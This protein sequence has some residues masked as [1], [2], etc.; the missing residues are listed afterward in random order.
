MAYPNTCRFWNLFAWA[1]WSLVFLCAWLYLGLLFQYPVTEIT[2]A[3]G[4]RS[5]H[6]LSSTNL[7]NGTIN[8]GVIANIDVRDKTNSSYDSNISLSD[9]ISISDTTRTALVV[10]GMHRSGTSLL[11]NLLSLS[12]YSPPKTLCNQTNGTKTVIMNLALS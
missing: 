11:A 8:H 6:D 3:E 5:M 10:L 2:E 4:R 1:M 9:N 12:G 7:G